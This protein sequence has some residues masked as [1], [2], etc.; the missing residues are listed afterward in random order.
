M[1]SAILP[2][3]ARGEISFERGEGPYLFDADG[4]RY[5]DF[6]TGI[7]VACVGHSH[8]HLADAI[9]KQAQTLMHVS[10]LYTIPGQERLAERLTAN[11]FADF[12]FFCNSGAEANEALIKSAR[13]YHFAHDRPERY[14]IITFENAFHGRTLATIAATGQAKVLEGFGPKVEGFDHVPV[15]DIDAVRAAITDETAAVLIEPV[16][17]EGGIIVV[18][19]DRKSVV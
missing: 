6:G 2:T 16:Q 4:K 10:N 12:V 18:P 14:R 9:S 1:T 5:L 3:Y 11:S 15:G 8:P 13:R 19:E 7:A 17:G